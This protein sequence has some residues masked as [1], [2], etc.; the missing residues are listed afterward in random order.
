MADEHHYW[1]KNA[2]N[3][4]HIGQLHRELHVPEGEKIPAAKL[5]K[6]T[7]SSNEHIAKQAH[8]AETL[9]RFHK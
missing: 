5:E 7:H 4:E 8:L 2:I 6:A 3:P 9:R 1:I